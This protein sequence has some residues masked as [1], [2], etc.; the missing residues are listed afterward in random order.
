MIMTSGCALRAQQVWD[1]THKAN[2]GVSVPQAETGW[3]SAQ[4]SLAAP[5]DPEL[6]AWLA[7]AGLDQRT[8][9]PDRD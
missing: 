2:C 6:Q 3:A 8:A 5:L 1:M 9:K 4:S 7:R